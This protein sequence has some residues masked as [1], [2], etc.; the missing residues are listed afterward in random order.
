MEPQGHQNQVG[1]DQKQDSAFQMQLSFYF[2]DIHIYVFLL[3]INSLFFLIFF[4]AYGNPSN[5]NGAIHNKGR[6]TSLLLPL[7]SQRI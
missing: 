2:A 3:I 6:T 5:G 7:F 1:V 4:L